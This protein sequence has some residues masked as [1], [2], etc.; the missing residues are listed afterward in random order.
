[1]GVHFDG[2]L[3]LHV[4]RRHV[5]ALENS[6]LEQVA[7]WPLPALLFWG[8]A[9]TVVRHARVVDFV[10]MVGLARV[11]LLVAAVPVAYLSPESPAVPIKLTPELLVIVLIGLSG[12]AWYFTLLYQ[13]FKNA[14]GLNGAKL[15]GGF[16]GIS[17]L[18]EVGSK[19][20]LASAT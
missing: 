16:I 18:A 9:G 5:P 15:L 11:A 3:D 2:F 8:Y 13:G 10:G 17:I 20:V 7:G 12:I 1:L 19:V 6:L 4:S 14:S